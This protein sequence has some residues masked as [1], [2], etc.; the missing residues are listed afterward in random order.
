MKAAV[1]RRYG[2]PDV[3]QIAD[4]P[5]PEPKANEVLVRVR[6]TTVTA[7]DSR[8][9]S[10]RVPEG[11]GLLLRLGFGITGPRNPILG[12]EFSGEVA[13]MG[14]SATR[15][16]PGDRVFGA[17]MGCHAEYVT[18]RE[19]A[20][21]PLTDGMTFEQAAALTF[22]GLTAIT[23]LRDKAQLRPGERVLIN[24]ASGAVGTAAVQL[25]RH[26]GATVTGVCSAT[27]AEL[28]RSLGAEQVID[29]GLEDF[30]QARE[31]YD[32]IFD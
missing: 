5:K 10:A 20:I 25:A 19:G 15:F 24:G 27:N 32:V 16:K 8:I 12:M 17:R 2:R 29:Y 11:F 14:T 26:L 1:C 6:A 4:V 21:A 18:V 31:A 3:V 23:F 30:T 22:G 13:T 9:R 28:V 7:G